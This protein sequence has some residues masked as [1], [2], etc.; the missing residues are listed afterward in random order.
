MNQALATFEPPVDHRRNPDGNQNYSITRVWE[1]HAEIARMLVLGVSASAIAEQLGV[2][3]QTISNF[4]NS[5]LGKARILELQERRDK[6]IEN[7]SKRIAQVAPLAV[8]VLTK[9]LR[10]AVESEN[11]DKD[12]QAQGLKAAATILEYSAPKKF[13]EASRPGHLTSSRI[14]EIK[15]LALGSAGEQITET[16]TIREVE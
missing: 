5:D 13:E 8:D 15:R 14:L 12:V 3:P 4:R 6:E 1:Q 10:E 7:I 11:F 2:T 9:S 16:T